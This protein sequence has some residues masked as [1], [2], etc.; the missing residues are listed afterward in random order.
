MAV[1]ALLPVVLGAGME[2]SAAATKSGLEDRER[3]TWTVDVS[4]GMWRMTREL[5]D[6]Y[7]VIGPRSPLTSSNYMDVL[8]RIA[9]PGSSTPVLRRVLYRCDVP[10][11]GATYRRCVRYESAANATQAAGAVPTGADGITVI[12]RLVNGTDADPVFHD[13]YYPPGSAR[14]TFATATAKIPVTGERK[15]FNQTVGAFD[16]GFYMRNLDLVR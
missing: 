6:A 15:S 4:A 13:F 8:V 5:R 16:D 12:D 9:R 14:P 1:M 11:T 2:L 10:V 7:G 3:S